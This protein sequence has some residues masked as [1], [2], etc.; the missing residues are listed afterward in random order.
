MSFFWIIVALVALLGLAYWGT[1]RHTRKTVKLAQQ[2][3]IH[4]RPTQRKAAF[5]TSSS[6]PGES[7]RTR[8]SS[9]TPRPKSTRDLDTHAGLVFTPL[10]VWDVP[11]QSVDSSP[12]PPA[13]PLVEP[14]AAVEDDNRYRTVGGFGGESYASVSPSSGNNDS[15]ASPS[16]SSDDYSSSG[17]SDSSSPS[18]D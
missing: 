1:V 7:S 17:S 12:Q 11:S 14:V 2:Q 10:P 3:A 6:R 9:S 16:S 15:Y 4:A 5:V 8:H 13:F 18:M